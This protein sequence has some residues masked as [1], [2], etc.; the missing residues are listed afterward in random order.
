METQ[1]PLP[2]NCNYSAFDYDR[3]NKTYHHYCEVVITKNGNIH[4]A[5]PSH[6]RFLEDKLCKDKGITRTK[7]AKLLP[8]ERWGDYLEWLLEQTE[9]ICVWYDRY[10][11]NP[12]DMQQATL[13]KLQE[14]GC[15]DFTNEKM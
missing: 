5:H 8:R 1:R 6:Q 3:H 15:V 10:I 4:Y 12:N 11:G 7:L 14:K 13:N 9:C 2:Y